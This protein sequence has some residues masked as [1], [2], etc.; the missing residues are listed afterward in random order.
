MGRQLL[1]SGGTAGPLQSGRPPAQLLPAGRPGSG[2]RCSAPCPPSAGRPGASAAACTFLPR[3]RAALCAGAGC[4]E[5]GRRL[6][7]PAGPG[8]PSLN[9]AADQQHWSPISA[10]GAPLHVPPPSVPMTPLVTW[11]GNEPAGIGQRWKPGDQE[12]AQV[13]LRQ[14]PNYWSGCQ[15][16][17]AS[18]SG[19][20]ELGSRWGSASGPRV[21]SACGRGSRSVRALRSPPEFSRLHL[22]SL[23]APT[24]R[25]PLQGHKGTGSSARGQ[26][27][28]LPPPQALCVVALEGKEFKRTRNSKPPETP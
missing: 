18:G 1:R 20:G 26:K 3:D 21:F 17:D 2:S 5:F 10:P 25:P 11:A 8:P 23:G 4:A 12:G 27:S 13:G 24:P 22:A 16:P 9:Q 28:P 19:T 7:Q 6:L 14:A 15:V